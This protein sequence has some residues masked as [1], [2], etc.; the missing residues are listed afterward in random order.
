MSKFSKFAVSIL[1]LALS[2]AGCSDKDP[3]EKPAPHTGN[4]LFEEEK[5][6]EVIENPLREIIVDEKI[7][8]VSTSRLNVRSAPEISESNLVGALGLNDEVRILSEIADTVF[9]KIQIV[10]TNANIEKAEAYYVS[11]E[12]LSDKK[13]EQIAQAPRS[14]F[15]MIQNV[16]TERM[17]VYEKKCDDGR[18][19]HKLVLEADIAVGEKTKSRDTMTVLG[20]FNV[21]KWVKFYQDGAGRYP[22][23]Y[24]PSYPPVPKPKAGVLDWTKD[25]VMPSRGGDVRGAFGWYTAHV[26]PNSHSQWT[27]GTLGWGSDKKKYI[28]ATRKFFANLF[29]DP[30]SH[31]CTRTDNETIA[32]VRELIEAG[33]PI[34]KVYARE[35]LADASRSRY[36]S[37]TQSWSYILTKNGVR[38]D[39]EKP[40]RASVLARGTPQSQWLEEGQ[41]EV[42]VYPDV[43]KF[44]SGSGGAKSG[45]NGNVYGLDSSDMRGYLLVDEGRLVDYSHPSQLDTGGY[46]R[47]SFPEYIVAKDAPQPIVP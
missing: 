32:Y 47:N 33:A 28:D 26:G 10:K 22:S 5:A 27:H 43:D 40:D 45:R 13:N 23:W 6:P 30:R 34:V 7:Y 35:A 25:K 46:G 39:G 42:D 44:K 15:F 1:I 12:Y 3:A 24:D 20:N 41:Y 19:A 8:Y 37:S 17:R 14:R 9:V 2:L 21:T 29:A 11:K 18:C 36:T 16:A 4:E 31:G 38:V